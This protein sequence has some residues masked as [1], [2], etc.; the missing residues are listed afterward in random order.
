MNDLARAIETLTS[1]ARQRS[2]QHF[3]AGVL[4]ALTLDLLPIGVTTTKRRDTKGH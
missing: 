3:S 2:E 1:G 4:G